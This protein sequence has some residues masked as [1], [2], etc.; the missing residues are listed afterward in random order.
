MTKLMVTFELIPLVRN[1]ML[2][3]NNK[4]FDLSNLE[5]YLPSPVMRLTLI[6][7]ELLEFEDDVPL[8]PNKKKL[9]IWKM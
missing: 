2:D 5:Y 3:S 7:G 8:E 1:K 6:L 9:V 4:K